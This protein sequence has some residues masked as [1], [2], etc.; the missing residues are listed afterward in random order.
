MGR[1]FWMPKLH[2]KLTYE[3]LNIYWFNAI[4]NHIKS[5]FQK[6]AVLWQRKRYMKTTALAAVII[7]ITIITIITIIT[8]KKQESA[9]AATVRQS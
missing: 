6:G 9:V 5:V 8:W 1:P 7:T 4:I 2:I 3:H